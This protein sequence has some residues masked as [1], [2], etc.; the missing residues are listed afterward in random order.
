MRDVGSSDAPRPAPCLPALPELPTYQLPALG[1][2]GCSVRPHI[3]PAALACGDRGRERKQRQAQ[4]PS[5]QD[6]CRG[7]GGNAEKQRRGCTVGP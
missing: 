7:R 5:P 1:I 2:L 6:L 4:S 3:P